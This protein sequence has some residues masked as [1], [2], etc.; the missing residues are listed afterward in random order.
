MK[1]GYRR[2][3]TEAAALMERYYQPALEALPR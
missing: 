3:A 1:M 2:G